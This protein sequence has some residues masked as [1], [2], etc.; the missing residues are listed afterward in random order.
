MEA[1]D[2]LEHPVFIASSWIADED[3]LQI[4]PGDP[5]FMQRYTLV[6]LYFYTSGDNW[7]RCTR[8]ATTPCIDE[9]F[10]SD[11]HECNWGGVTCDSL[12]RVKKLNLGKSLCKLFHFYAL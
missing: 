10:L 4:C 5:K 1:F 6:L 7:T 2:D 11:S 12:N 8:D 9:R 3:P